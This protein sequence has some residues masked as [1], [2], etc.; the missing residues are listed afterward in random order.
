MQLSVHDIQPVRKG[1][2]YLAGMSLKSTFL[3]LKKVVQVVQIGG[4]GR[5]GW[6]NLYKTQNNS[7]FF[8]ETFPKVWAR[9]QFLERWKHHTG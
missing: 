3:A 2:Y 7:I 5:G 4:R 9:L 6:C 8:R 1:C